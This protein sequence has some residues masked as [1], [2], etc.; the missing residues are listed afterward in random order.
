MADKKTF[1]ADPIGSPINHPSYRKD[2]CTEQD[3]SVAISQSLHLGGQ[4]VGITYSE[5]AAALLSEWCDWESD[6]EYAYR[7]T[8][9]EETGERTWRVHLC[10]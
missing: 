7:G 2:G 3:V 6:D 5:G 8:S 9:S 10:S 1:L 4:S